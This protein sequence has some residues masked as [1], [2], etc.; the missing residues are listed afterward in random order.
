M[1]KVIDGFLDRNFKNIKD[2]INIEIVAH[3]KDHYTV[4]TADGKVFVSA[5]NYISAFHGLYAYLQKYCKVQYSW[6]GTDTIDITEL[7]MFSGE[8]SNTIEQKW[9]VYLNYCTLDYTSAWWDFARWEKELDEFELNFGKTYC[10]YEK[11]E[12]SDVIPSA[13]HLS[14]KWN[15]G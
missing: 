11:P 2:K 7:T 13:K 6:C 1:D 15:I 14:K 5:N 10:E 4:K 3:E 12:N 9:R 8:F